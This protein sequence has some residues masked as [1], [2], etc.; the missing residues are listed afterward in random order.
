MLKGDKMNIEKRDKVRTR[1]GDGSFILKQLSET[2]AVYVKLLEK[3]KLGNKLTDEEKIELRN[4]AYRL[5]Y[6]L[7]RS[8]EA[9]KVKE[10]HNK[11]IMKRISSNE[12]TAEKVEEKV[13]VNSKNSGWIADSIPSEVDLPMIDKEKIIGKEIKII[14]VVPVKS[15]FPNQPFYGLSHIEYE[16]SKY[17]AAFPPT[18]YNKL[19]EIGMLPIMVIINKRQS[20]ITGYEYYYIEKHM[21]IPASKNTIIPELPT[22]SVLL[23]PM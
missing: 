13:E 18:V 20:L 17:I 16:G 23:P 22:E 11:M 5:R 4:A 12:H 3:K 6:W 7:N 8:E 19:K 2:M 14:D 1:I 10:R 21:N 15:K 9:K